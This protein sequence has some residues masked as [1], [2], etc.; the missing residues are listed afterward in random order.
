MSKCVISSCPQRSLWDYEMCETSWIECPFLFIAAADLFWIPILWEKN[1]KSIRNKP[2]TAQVDAPLKVQKLKVSLKIH[3]GRKP[4][5]PNLKHQKL[6]LKLSS[7]SKSHSA[8]KGALSSPNAFFSGKKKQLWKWR[9][10]PLTIFFEEKSLSAGKNR[11]SFR[12]H[13]E[14][15]SSGGTAMSE[16]YEGTLF[17]V[18]A[19]RVKS[20]RLLQWVFLVGVF[21]ENARLL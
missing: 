16:A 4:L 3:K 19:F 6:M 13:W 10:Y 18:G 21:E 5:L 20:A 1:G 8:E 12:N 9:G 15:V 7:F 17:V 2:G 14:N 11:R